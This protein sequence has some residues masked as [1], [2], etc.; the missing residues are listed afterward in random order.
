MAAR[1]KVYN[2]DESYD[3]L[4]APEPSVRV[5]LSDL[6]PIVEMAHRR[7]FT[8]LKDFLEDEVAISDDLYDV[9]QNFSRVRP[10][11]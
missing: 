5:R 8:W 6:L 1:L 2:A 9:L 10:G 7:N 11:A 4:F 3:D